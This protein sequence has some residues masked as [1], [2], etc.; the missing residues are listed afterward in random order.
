MRAIAFLVEVMA[1]LTI[2]VIFIILVSG[3]AVFLSTAKKIINKV[4]N[5]KQNK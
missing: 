3:W 2:A 5:K 1:F 4:L